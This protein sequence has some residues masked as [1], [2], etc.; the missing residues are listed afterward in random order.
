MGKMQVTESTKITEY[1]WTPKEAVDST[2]FS[3]TFLACTHSSPGRSTCH[4]VMSVYTP[5]AHCITD[6]KTDMCNL[7]LPAR[8]PSIST[9]KQALERINTIVL[10]R[11]LSSRAP[12]LRRALHS[13]PCSSGWWPDRRAGPPWALRGWRSTQRLPISGAARPCSEEE[14]WNS[15]Y[16]TSNSEGN[17]MRRRETR[18]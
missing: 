5:L 12:N 11:Q 9:T 10:R 3:R 1:V 18:R 16:K 13:D 7:P 2:F 8:C 14:Q 15:E 6:S 4:A 17:G